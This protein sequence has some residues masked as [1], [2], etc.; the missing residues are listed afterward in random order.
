MTPPEGGA[1]QKIKAVIKGL[2]T[3]MEFFMMTLGS[4]LLAVGVALFEIPNNFVTGGVS[5]VALVIAKYLSFL[6]PNAWI[7][8]LNV[9]LLIIAFFVLGKQTGIKTV[10]C[11]LLYSLCARLAELI[12]GI[13]LPLSGEPVL[14]LVYAILFTSLGCALNFNAGGSSGGTD[15]IALIL[16]K[17]TKLNIGVVLFATDF[18][19]AGSAFFVFGPQTGMLSMLGLLAKSFF[20]DGAMESFH[21][22]KYFVVITKKEGEILDFIMHTMERGVTKTTGV[23]AW[24]GE[25]RTMLHTVCSRREA[26]RLRDTIKRIDPDAFT[27]ITTS[28]EIIGFGFINP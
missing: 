6:S 13:S 1:M 16:K 3:P 14:E 27:I 7:G 28:S 8:V 12:P 10:Y 25:E 19:V 11:S 20:V 21:A 2:G 24:T 22:C 17:Y 23:G 4:V 18:L 9:L 5:S 26:V 15:I